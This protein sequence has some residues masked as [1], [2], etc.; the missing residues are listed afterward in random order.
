[1]KLSILKLVFLL[2]FRS[3][4]NSISCIVDYNLFCFQNRLYLKLWF[5]IF[6]YRIDFHT[7]IYSSAHI[8][9]NLHECIQTQIT[10]S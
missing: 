6:G 8:Y 2:H 10:F 5:I 1:M 7:Q 4:L 3:L 9:K